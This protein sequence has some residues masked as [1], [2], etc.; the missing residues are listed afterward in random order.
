MLHVVAF[1]QQMEVLLLGTFWKFFANISFSF[2]FF[3][4]SFIRSTP[5]AYGNSWA[6]GLIGAA[7]MLAPGLIC[8]LHC[9]LWQQQIIN[10]PNETRDQTF[11]FTDAS[12]VVNPQWELQH[13]F[14]FC[15]CLNPRMQNLG[16]HRPALFHS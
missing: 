8:Y 5:T 10:T 3:F 12:R 13:L 16:I 11:V 4:L 15:S 1:M 7:A 14:S 6:R 9:S 2:F